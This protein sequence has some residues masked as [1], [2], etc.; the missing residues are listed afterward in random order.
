MPS[1]HSSN[2]IRF[3]A[4]SQIEPR[5]IIERFEAVFDG[6][7]ERTF[8]SAVESGIPN[9][10]RSVREVGGGG[11]VRI[12]GTSANTTEDITDWK[13]RTQS[14][15]YAR[16]RTARQAVR[17]NRLNEQL[18]G[19]ALLEG[20][21]MDNRAYMRGALKDTYH[22]RKRFVTTQTYLWRS[23]NLVTT[24]RKRSLLTDSEEEQVVN[25]L[26]D[27]WETSVKLRR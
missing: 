7:L 13:G 17:A 14:V 15:T 23:T 4:I 3:E 9:P 1:S 25:E 2:M 22:A 8:G 26:H 18:F 10:L 11:E 24:Y 21:V 16:I 19:P 5:G 20:H 12:G 6:L 27:I